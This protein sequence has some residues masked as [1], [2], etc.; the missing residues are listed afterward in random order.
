M[1]NNRYQYVGAY[2]RKSRPAFCDGIGYLYYLD[3]VEVRPEEG[4]IY[5]TRAGV[6]PVP[7]TPQTMAMLDD[8]GEFTPAQLFCQ[9]QFL[10]SDYCTNP[11]L[12][13]KDFCGFHAEQPNIGDTQVGEDDPPDLGLLLGD[14]D[15]PLPSA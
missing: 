1:R 12:E 14:E 5:F 15:V 7:L 8:R 6:K 4:L 11:P 10:T 2:G 3:T 13:G 9:H